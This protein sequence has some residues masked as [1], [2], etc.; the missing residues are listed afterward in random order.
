MVSSLDSIMNVD[1]DDDDNEN[2]KIEK[3]SHYLMRFDIG[4]K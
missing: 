4:N 1:N 3:I 2:G